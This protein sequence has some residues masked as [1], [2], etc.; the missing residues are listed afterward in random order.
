[1]KKLLILALLLLLP[2]TAHA[3]KQATTKLLTA[4]D[5]IISSYAISNG[6]TVTTDSIYQPGNVGFSSMA[7]DVSGN[8]AVSY[9]VSKDGTKWYSPYTTDGASLT[10]VSGIVTSVTA[11]RWIIL[12]AKLAPY[13]RY[14]FTST[15][16]ST[17][18]A[19]LVWQDE[20]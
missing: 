19:T 13:V 6:I 10:D 17:I 11:D 2:L 9:Q 15:G 4:S 12:T 16:S 1:M 3:G 5:Q 18:T 20:M 8:V 7:L 14:K